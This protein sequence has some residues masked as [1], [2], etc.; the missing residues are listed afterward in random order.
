[1]FREYEH[2]AIFIGVY[3]FNDCPYLGF[4]RQH[5]H[6]GSGDEEQQRFE[7]SIPFRRSGGTGRVDRHGRGFAVPGCGPCSGLHLNLNANEA[8]SSPG[9]IRLRVFHSY[10]NLNKKYFSELRSASHHYAAAQHEIA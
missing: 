2:S 4:R 7:W 8:R 1:L 5:L 9:F 10:L 6:G 3:R